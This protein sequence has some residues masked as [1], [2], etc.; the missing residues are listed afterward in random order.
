MYIK[1]HGEN[2]FLFFQI[3]VADCEKKRGQKVANFV[4]II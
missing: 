2:S 4:N 3:L 1:K